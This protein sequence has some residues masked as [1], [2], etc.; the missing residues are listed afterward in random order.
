MDDVTDKRDRT[1][2]SGNTRADR[3][4]SQAGIVTEAS[5][6]AFIAEHI[7][8][9]R[10]FFMSRKVAREDIDDLVQESLLV[11]WSKRARIREDKAKQFLTGISA[12]V[13]LRY[14]RTAARKYVLWQLQNAARLDALQSRGQHESVALYP[15]RTDPGDAEHRSLVREA[16]QDLPPVMRE[17][18]LLR[19]MEGCTLSETARR[20]GKARQTVH[21][22]EKGAI[23]RLARRIT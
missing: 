10:R 21:E 3:D 4:S 22:A 16:V 9:L 20:L 5:L 13:L 23:R 17:V 12:R 1:V 19:F 11:F 6:P 18:I 14:K 15:L 2:Q 8:P 7:V